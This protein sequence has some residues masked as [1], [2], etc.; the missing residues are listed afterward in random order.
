MVMKVD[1]PA[2]PHDP[3]QKTFNF[4]IQIY[5][6]GIAVKSSP[7]FCPISHLGLIITHHWV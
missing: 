1:L 3:P 5:G 2:E 7:N 4:A 6:K